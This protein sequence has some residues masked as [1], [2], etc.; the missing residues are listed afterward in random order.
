VKKSPK[1]KFLTD[2]VLAMA[3]VI[4]SVSAVYCVFNGLITYS[5]YPPSSLPGS[6]LPSSNLSPTANFSFSSDSM[7]VGG[8]VQFTDLSSGYYTILSWTWDFG[9]GWTSTYQN[10]TH[11]YS[12]D[13]VYTVKLIVRDSAGETATCSKNIAIYPWV[14]EDGESLNEF[15][16]CNGGYL[17]GGNGHTITLHNNQNAKNPTWGELMSFLQR[18]TTDQIPYVV[19]SFVCADYAERL[20]NNAEGAGIRAAYVCVK[21]SGVGHACNAFRTTDRGLVFIDDTNSLTPT[22]CDKQ[23]NIVV[24]QDYVPVSLFSSQQFLSMGTVNSYGI[25]W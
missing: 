16:M 18:D 15:V 6:N 7:Q 13:G 4:L 3:I 11:S 10:P 19:G 22:N 12:S 25:Q 5:Q 21:L 24:G 23:V 20:H 8:I 17:V 2:K 14:G 9:D 1:S